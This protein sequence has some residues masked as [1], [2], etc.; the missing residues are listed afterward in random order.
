MITDADGVILRI[1]RAFTECTGYTTE[2]VV[3]QTS[4]LLKS[5]LHNEDFYRE[6]WETIHR[7]G[8]WQGEVWDR[9][10]N[11]EIYPKWL[12]LSAVKMDDGVVTHYVGAH[13]D[14]TERKAAEE[15][16]SI[17]RST[18][19]SPTCPTGFFCKTGSNRHCFP[20]C[21]TV[22]EARCYSLT[23]TISRTSTI[24]WDMTAWDMLLIQATQ[25][26][27]VCIR[28][29]TPWPVWGVTIRGDAG[30]PERATYRSRRP[31]GSHRR[32]NIAAL[33]QP[34]Q[35]DKNTYRCTAS[36]GVTWFGGHLKAA[37][38]LMKQSDIAMY[39]ARKLAATPCDS[40][41]ARCRK[42][43]A[44]VALE[45][46]LQN[47]LEF[48]QFH[49]YYQIQVD[50]SYRPL[51]A[52]ALIRWTHPEH[53]LVSPAQFIPLAEETGQ[54]LPIGLWVLETACAQLKVWQHDA[55][56][57]HLTLAVNVSARHIPPERFR[58]SSAI[59]RTTS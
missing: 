56:T 38:E 50:S 4:R 17:W 49:L 10:K 29:A 52:E 1:N 33:S 8:V 59:F 47:A 23:W 34:Y 35:L 20:V 13:I 6:M 54:I 5:G 25:R 51:G 15:K 3:G 55:L 27:Q 26:L 18:T 46:E 12:S 39:Q 28:K 19:T 42:I 32:E 58:G 24:R 16:I 14:I 37:D 22:G 30:R 48:Q 53:G 57:R 2:D 41:T 7:T 21:I 31:D 44:R 36:I 11:G 45:G 40:S 9:R 43:S